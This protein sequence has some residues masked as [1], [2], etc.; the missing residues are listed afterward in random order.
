[1]SNEEV[2][3]KTG[4]SNR[5]FL[6]CWLLLAIPTAIGMTRLAHLRER[7]IER[8]EL[9]ADERTLLV[10]ASLGRAD[11]R[12][13]IQV[14]LIDADSCETR[15]TITHRTTEFPRPFLGVELSPNGR[16]LALAKP[17]SLWIYD[18]YRSR[19]QRPI[20]FSVH[21]KTYYSD[22]L[23]TADSRFLLMPQQS[24]D[25]QRFV[26]HNFE[27]G[28]SVTARTSEPLSRFFKLIPPPSLESEA[29]LAGVSVSGDGESTPVARKTHLFAVSEGSLHELKTPINAL[30]VFTGGLSRDLKWAMRYF[31]RKDASGMQQT[32]GYEVVDSMTGAVAWQSQDLTVRPQWAGADQLVS[33]SSTRGKDPKLT[34]SVIDVPSGMTKHQFRFARDPILTCYRT[35]SGEM[36]FCTRANKIEATR[37]DGGSRLVYHDSL[38]RRVIEAI[39]WILIAITFWSMVTIWSQRKSRSMQPLAMACLL[40][41]LVIIPLALRYHWGPEPRFFDFPSRLSMNGLLIGLAWLT[42]FWSAFSIM[43][44]PTRVTLVL[45]GVAI[46]LSIVALFNQKLDKH[47]LPQTS[48]ILS[49]LFVPLLCFVTLRLLRIRMVHLSDDRVRVIRRSSDSLR[50]GDLALWTLAAA[51]VLLFARH[52]TLFTNMESTRL[53]LSRALPMTLLGVIIAWT[54]AG[55]AATWI[56]LCIGSVLLIVLVGRSLTWFESDL[57]QNQELWWG[58]GIGLIIVGLVAVMLRINGYRVRLSN[59]RSCSA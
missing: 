37:P 41:S 14:K 12:K 16:Y 33:T 3:A 10:Q 44:W 54:A 46:L 23:F 25:Q 29:T 32:G 50:I 52:V 36:F 34:M 53:A 21:Q 55:A 28:A 35:Q 13:E 59:R 8:L 48:Q 19:F 11:E 42:A 58:F 47:A 18:T 38:R 4:V 57:A 45:L 6:T 17:D 40:A 1:M 27:N 9:S 7:R 31:N 43:R 39:A 22:M 15:F 24:G 56:R 30:N 26:I 49:V 5:W 20:T 51:I 2:P